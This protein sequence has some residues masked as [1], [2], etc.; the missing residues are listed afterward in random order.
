MGVIVSYSGDDNANNGALMEYRQVGSGAWKPG[1]PMTI[2]RRV[3]I[4]HYL[5]SGNGDR[6]EPNPWGMQARAVILYL[7]PDTDYEVRVTF[8]DPDGVAGSSVLT[9]TTTTRNDNPPSNGQTYYVS[10]GGSDSN[11]GT[12]AQPFRTIQHAADVVA[13]GDRVLV[14]PGT[15]A[16]QVVVS[17]KS[18][19]AS[20]YISFESTVERGAVIDGG[21]SRQYN[22]LVQNSDY[23]RISGFTLQYAAS[24]PIRV[25]G[26]DHGIIEDNYVYEGYWSGDYWA[27]GGIWLRDNSNFTLIQRNE[28]YRSRNGLETM[29]IFISSGRTS[30]ESTCGAGW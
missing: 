27:R 22:F 2:D 9:G 17:G 30:A 7:Q 26:S 16:E 10:T 11:P 5:G 25:E 14:L 8:T 24:N 3:Q 15:Y 1:I 28:I 19:T 29:G 21:Q 18:G 13:T 23:V 20:N 6:T 12:S 4:T